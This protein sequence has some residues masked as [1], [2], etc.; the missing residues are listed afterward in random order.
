MTVRRHILS[1]VCLLALL[2]GSLR[3]DEKKPVE[4][5]WKGDL[6]LGFSLSKGNT[7]AT[8]FSFTFSVDGP[9]NA[10]KTMIWINKGVLLFSETNGKTN[11][12]SLLANSRIDWQWNGRLFSYFEFQ[13]QRDRF[14]NFS[15]RLL[16]S[17]GFG[18]KFLDSESVVFTLDGGLSQ[19]FTKY[20]DTGDTE[21]YTGL[22]GG[23]QFG[24]KIS[25]T[26]EIIEVLQINADLARLSDF[27]FR[28]EVNLVTAIT[29]SWSVKLTFVESYDNRPVGTRIKKNDITFIAGISRKF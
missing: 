5:R 1:A 26:A 28:L 20:Y 25:K 7:D 10:A 6:S 13:G 19:V 8:S 16:P 22:K 2:A 29:Q 18:Y 3:P 24:W 17:F 15:Y 23:Q 12:E 21:N 4:P 14:K 11:S 9:I 27:F